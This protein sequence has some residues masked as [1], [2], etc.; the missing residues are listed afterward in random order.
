LNLAVNGGKRQLLALIRSHKQGDDLYVLRFAVVVFGH[1]LAGGQ[2]LDVL[3]DYLR[4]FDL[5]VL[6]RRATE[7]YVHAASRQDEAG[8][9]DH[10]IDLDADRSHAVGN[11]RRQSRTAAYRGKF[12]I[13]NRLVR[14]HWDNHPSTNDV[15]NLLETA[16]ERNGTWPGR[17][18]KIGFRKPRAEVHAL[19]RNN[20]LG[21]IVRRLQSIA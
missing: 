12:R 17:D 4:H 20:N 7:N 5:A 15:S 13:E 9:A 6:R 14:D 19:C 10:V 16:L 8:H 11:N 2:H 21:H 18:A 1:V 3:E